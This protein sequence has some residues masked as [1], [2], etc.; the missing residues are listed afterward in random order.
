MLEEEEPSS[1]V[2]STAAS[3]DGEGDG[4]E[5]QRLLNVFSWDPV[6]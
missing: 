3:E 6:A 2:R 1:V 4:L 5:T